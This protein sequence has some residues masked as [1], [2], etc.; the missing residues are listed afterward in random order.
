MKRT[1]RYLILISATC[2]AALGLHG[3]AENL[4][5]QVVDDLTIKG[6]TSITLSI[7]CVAGPGTGRK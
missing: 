7:Y 3:Q 6:N 5:K 2:L 1:K 4:T